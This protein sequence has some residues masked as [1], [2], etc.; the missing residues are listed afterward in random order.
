MKYTDVKYIAFEGGGGKGIVYLGAVRALEAGGKLPLSKAMRDLPTS[1]ILDGIAGASAGAITAY[2]LAL[3]MSAED[4]AARAKDFGKFYDDPQP[5]LYKGVSYNAAADANLPVLVVDRIQPEY[6]TR[7][8]G[9][10]SESVATSISA[11]QTGKIYTDA[12]VA[13]AAAK[14]LY[15]FYRFVYPFDFVKLLLRVI[16]GRKKLKKFG[17]DNQLVKKMTESFSGFL[18]YMYSILF[19]RGALSGM[20]IRTYLQE[21]TV[22][23]LEENFGVVVSPEDAQRLTFAEFYAHTRNDLRIAGSNVTKGIPVYFSRYLTPD[24]PVIEAICMSMSIPFA[25]KP[26]LSLAWA[27]KT[28]PFAGEHNDRY[29]GFFNDGG[30]L[31]NLPIHAFDFGPDDDNFRR[32]IV[33]LDDGIFGIR[34]TGGNPTDAE[35]DPKFPHDANYLR[36]L[37]SKNEGVP[38]KDKLTPDK[39]PVQA[40]KTPFTIEMTQGPFTPVAEFAGNVLNA[41]MYYQEDGQIRSEDEFKQT[42]ELF[43]YDVKLFDFT[44]FE[45]LSSFVQGRA[46]IKVGAML[47]IPQSDITDLVLQYYYSDVEDP[48]GIV[49]YIDAAYRRAQ[50]FKRRYQISE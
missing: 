42:M 44:I 41:L 25:F 3:G 15:A 22:K 34:C 32:K 11:I 28:K 19:D 2:F 4:V 10:N 14:K 40:L 35:E 21:L 16:G 45:G 48:R 20:A 5:A 8:L 36:Y 13:A 37:D 12:N 26:T 46:A 23:Q 33:E 9:G 49:Q 7:D 50:E 43:S 6:E 18:Q 24:F 30:M 17:G 38:E 1:N 47:N 31:N 29:V 39:V 27:D